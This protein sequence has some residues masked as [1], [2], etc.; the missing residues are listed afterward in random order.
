MRT[1]GLYVE[2][3]PQR[4]KTMVHVI[5]LLGCI[6]NGPTTDD[7]LNATPDSI[8]TYLR[9]LKRHGE[10]ADPDELFD[11]TIVEHITNGTW[12]GNGSPYIIYEP[13]FAPV[14]RANLDV[15]VGRFHAMRDE[16]VAWAEKQDNE[17]LDRDASPGRTS[18]AILYHVVCN[19]GYY[20]TPFL[21]A[22]RGFSR[23]QHQTERGE[24]P[25]I[26][27]FRTAE[28][29]VAEL[30]QASTP[31]Q[32]SLVEERPNEVR[33]LRKVIRHVLEHDWEHLREL[34][35]RPGGPQL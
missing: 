19:P 14:T 21:G 5:D 6:A 12:L 26:E 32:R 33:T 25:I 9:F 8:R 1:Y 10:D 29:W 27:A 28:T 13:D 18:R 11:T 24:V 4:R 7:A 23:L 35:R 22:K 3:G 20:L 2:S 16:F 17:S 30:L 34:S 15:F 31:E